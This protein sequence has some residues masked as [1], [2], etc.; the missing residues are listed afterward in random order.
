M[1][2][3]R[4]RLS[5]SGLVFTA[6]VLTASACTQAVPAQN[7]FVTVSNG[8]KSPV[9]MAWQSPGLLGTPVLGGSGTDPIDACS[10]AGRSFGAGDQ[11]ITVTSSVGSQSFVLRGPPNGAP[12]V[13]VT[14]AVDATG[15]IT[16][17]AGPAPS[18]ACQP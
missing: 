18:T 2:A 9:S 14:I 10:S 17:L 7:L 8:S 1:S 13:T 16:E 5:L 3:A 11:H 6:A 15:A 12:S 4:M